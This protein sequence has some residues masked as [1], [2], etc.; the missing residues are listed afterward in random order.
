MRRRRPEA[1][2]TRERLRSGI[3]AH[4]ASRDV[5]RALYGAI[6]GLALVVA[7]QDHP[8]SA[9]EAAAAVL[10]TALA[11]GL[12]E[13]YSEAIAHEARTRRPVDRAGLRAIAGEAAAVMAG[14]AFPAVYF[15]LAA[16]GVLG[17]DTAFRL[18]KWS[19]LALIC[20]YGYFAARLAGSAPGRSLAHAAAV[21]SIG[22]TLIVLKALLH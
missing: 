6:I 16:M 3:D 7:L 12:A 21:G 10:A 4:L 20:A 13:M 18:S 1:L 8:P 11:V 15:L 2:T 22:G 19:G 9:G 14:A 5:A 17:L